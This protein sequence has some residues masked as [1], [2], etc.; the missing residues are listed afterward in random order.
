MIV[1]SIAFLI[2]SGW[3]ITYE[4]CWGSEETTTIQLEEVSGCITNQDQIEFLPMEET[5]DTNSVWYFNKPR[6]LWAFGSV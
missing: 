5:T 1:S 6:H 3:M 2:V 4:R